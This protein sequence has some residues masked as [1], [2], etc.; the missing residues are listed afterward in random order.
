M[1]YL[2]FVM[3]LCM[4]INAYGCCA[5]KTVV[6]ENVENN[7]QVVESTTETEVEIEVIE[8]VEEVIET[9]VEV[10]V[11]VENE[12][13][14]DVVTE[15]KEDIQTDDIT[16][17]TVIDHSEWDE[18]LQKHVSDQGNV[19]YK[20][21]K[22]DK[23]KFNAYL[24]MLSRNPPE[25]TWSKDETLAYWMNVYNAFTVK[26]I[27]DNYPTKS[28]KDI[29]GPWNHRF[30]KIDEKW[31][32][33]NDVEHKIIRKMDEPRIH[34]ALVCAAVS[35]P[36]LY[37]KA[38]TAKTLEADLDLLTRG[39]LSDTSKNEFSENAIKLSKIFKW[40]G[41]DFK[42]GG[43]NLI[44]FLNQYS[45]VKISSKAKKSYKDYNWTL[46]E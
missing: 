8:V 21:F 44:D 12:V 43:K 45:E 28:I 39:F 33:L 29:N 16:I 19:S 5:T 42:K 41:G 23:T 13:G 1:N 10:E 11:E 22:A 26:L 40:Y 31:Y 18:L 2:K 25:D 34:F 17:H 4:S 3:A 9:E 27:L 20:G 32:T 6:T 14:D 36:R 35:C 38:F 30:I 46:N 24:D 7:T 37:N 15:I